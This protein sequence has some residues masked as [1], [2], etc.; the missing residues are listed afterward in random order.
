MAIKF[1]LLPEPLFLTP[2]IKSIV[3]FA[4]GDL[5]IGD[6]T[7]T[8]AIIKSVRYIRIRISN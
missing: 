1:S 5:G 4:N 6:T 7:K 2:D 8:N 3:K